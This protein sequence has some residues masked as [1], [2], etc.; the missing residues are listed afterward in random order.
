MMLGYWFLL[1]ALGGSVNALQP[2]GGGVAFAAQVG[3]FLA[4]A[5]L[6]NV[7]KNR[8][9]VERREELLSSA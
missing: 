9:L 3:G 5:V 2:T 7:F 6:V 4:G 8:T 1:Q